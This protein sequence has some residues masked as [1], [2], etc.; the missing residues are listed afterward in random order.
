MLRKPSGNEGDVGRRV[1]TIILL[2]ESWTLESSSLTVNF[3]ATFPLL[4]AWL[5][6]SQ[7]ARQYNFLRGEEEGHIQAIPPHLAK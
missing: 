4:P 6:I 3:L 7:S 1:W 2:V 5:F